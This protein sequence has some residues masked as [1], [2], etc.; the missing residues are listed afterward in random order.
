MNELFTNRM[1][2]KIPVAEIIVRNDAPEAF[3]NYLLVFL[4]D[5]CGL[6]K[7][8]DI[9]CM[10]TNE[11]PDP[12][13]WGENDFMNSEIQTIVLNCPWYRIYD[14]IELFYKK[15]ENGQHA[16]FEQG[17]NNYFIEKGIG[18]KMISGKIETRGD[19]AFEADLVEV[20]T[21][22]L[23]RKL[24]TSKR[25]IKEAIADLSRRPNP[26]ITGAVQHSLAA[27]ESVCREVTGDKKAT[28][29]KLIYNHPDI[30]PS[31]LNVVIEK[32]WGFSSEQG[33]HLQE[34]RAPEYDEA[35]LLVHLSAAVCSY[36]CKKHIKLDDACLVAGKLDL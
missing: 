9:V 33:R 15:I 3:R 18:W 27:L 5:F 23:E 25:E 14:I 28:L 35:E 30:V 8:R 21:V 1:G 13:N 11:A 32:I 2:I 34:G 12:G 36:V 22:L 10:A 31:P 4:K 20:E 17:I 16:Q 26:E 19:E 7:I 6:R 29:G 24:Y